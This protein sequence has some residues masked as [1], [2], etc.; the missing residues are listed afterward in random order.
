MPD[1]ANGVDL[2]PLLTF[3]HHQRGVDFSGYKPATLRRRVAREM[4]KL[5]AETIEDYLD[6][7][8]VEPATVDDLFNSLLI[9]ATSFFRDRETWDE[10]ENN[11]LPRLVGDNESPIR[12]WS[13]GCASGQEPYSLAIALAE[14]LGLPQFRD[15]VKIYATDIDEEALAQARHA[16]Y[17]DKELMSVP[18]ER[19]ATYFEPAGEGAYSFRQDLRRRVVFGRNNLV[20]DPP[21]SRIALITCRNT[22]MYFNAGL[23]RQ[24]LDRLHFALAPNGVLLLGKAET[25]VTQDGL[26]A[27][28]DG[29]RR[30]F[31][32]QESAGREESFLLTS[33]I[34]L[35]PPPNVDNARLLGAALENGL[36]A[37]L[38][39]D[40]AGRLV[41]RNERAGALFKLGP[42]DVGRPI[43]DLEVSFRPVDLRP[44]LLE[45]RTEAQPVR[46]AGVEWLVDDSV[47]IV[48]VDVVPLHDGEFVGTLVAFAEV[49]H[50]KKLEDEL[51]LSKRRLQSAYE[52]LQSTNEEL[53]T[54]NEELQSTIEELETTNEEL[55]S[56]NEE[57]ETMNEELQSV[58]DE[59]YARDAEQRA[60]TKEASDLNYLFDFVLGMLNAGVVVVDDQL[61]VLTWNATARDLW[62]L[63]EDEAV[64]ERLAG[65][66]IGLPVDQLGAYVEALLDGH[67]TDTPVRVIE[68]I[69]RK[70]RKVEV[71]LTGKPLEDNGSR[72]VVVIMETAEPA[73]KT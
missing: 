54:T 62:G 3:L 64:G 59:L 25:L 26:F 12:V 7:L 4:T 23:Q 2:R 49:T 73:A 27:P 48:D 56:T 35:R 66:D 31:Q 14:C 18:E 39:L 1:D 30:F 21:M 72:R 17:T 5:S 42:E 29:K 9:N 33:P 36:V 50:A 22:L 34:A 71:R 57:L 15:R 69:N 13:A 43:L 40:R 58:N 53:E 46:R 65:L 37:Q 45:A 61:T 16:V 47:V 32:R 11:V 63:R 38:V 8:L 19:R 20:H 28:L 44:L 52:E 68:A 41:M 60:R 67:A 24:V 55:Q 70:G 10:L 51:R 6:M